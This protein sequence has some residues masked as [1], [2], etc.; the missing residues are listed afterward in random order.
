[1]KTDTLQIRLQPKEKE[2]FEIAAQLSGIGLSSWV[3]ERLRRSAIRE[4]EEANRQIP[5]LQVME[6]DSDGE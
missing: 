2:T 6:D 1:M 3:R 5:F 4:L